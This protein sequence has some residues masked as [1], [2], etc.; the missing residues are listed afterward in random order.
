MWDDWH[1]IEAAQLAAA[2]QERRG[3]PSEPPDGTG[4]SR[5]P[6]DRPR[7]LSS[8]QSPVHARSRP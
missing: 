6:Q 8:H 1:A 3:G 2:A 5:T 7:T 4:S